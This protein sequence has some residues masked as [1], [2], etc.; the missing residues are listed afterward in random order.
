M[1]PDSQDRGEGGHAGWDQPDGADHGT[2]AG[3]HPGAD[4][5]PQGS[6]AGRDAV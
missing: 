2:H 1:C 4:L 3:G 6:E 5:P